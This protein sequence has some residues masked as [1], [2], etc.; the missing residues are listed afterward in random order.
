M[1]KWRQTEW[2]TESLPLPGGEPLPL[3]FRITENV[4]IAKHFLFC[5]LLP[6]QVEECV[7]WDL[8]S[9]H[10]PSK[11]EEK[12]NMYFGC[13]L[14]YF[15]PTCLAKTQLLTQSYTKSPLAWLQQSSTPHPPE[16][17]S[18]S[19]SCIPW[20]VMQ[21]NCN[22]GSLIYVPAFMRKPLAGQTGTMQMG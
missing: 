15:P 7:L 17:G 18:H 13:L 6:F 11:P 21:D 9:P 12:S 10:P 16:F 8:G 3:S 19:N 14:N 20:E 2:Q 1:F 5:L 4:E 22:I